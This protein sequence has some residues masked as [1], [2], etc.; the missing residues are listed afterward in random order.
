MESGILADLKE[1]RE[2]VICTWGLRVFQAKGTACAKAMKQERAWGQGKQGSE[3]HSLL[4]SSR[5]T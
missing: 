2:P 3:L 4:F 1:V 5:G